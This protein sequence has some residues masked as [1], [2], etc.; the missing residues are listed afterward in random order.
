MNGIRARVALAGLAAVTASLTLHK[1]AFLDTPLPLKTTPSKLQ[2]SGYR[3]KPIHERHSSRGRNL[4]HN[5]I[6]QW[7]MYPNRGGPAL[8]LTLMPVRAR[9]PHDFQMASFQWIDSDLT[10]QDRRLHTHPTKSHNPTDIEEYAFGRGQYHAL[11]TT[12]RFQSCITPGG[13][14]GVTRGFLVTQIKLQQRR[15][16]RQA[17]IVSIVNRITGLNPHISWECLAVQIS[18]PAAGNYEQRLK[19]AWTSVAHALTA[20]PP[21]P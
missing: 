19:Q 3:M 17:P 5:M 11:G 18:T 7:R 1:I 10:L 4:S 16:F 8:R 12:T 14:A 13:S 2:I 9:Q 6:R 15:A 20:P 21:M